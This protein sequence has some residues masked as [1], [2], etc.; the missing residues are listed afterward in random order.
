[1]ILIAYKIGIAYD[2]IRWEER[3]L[4]NAFKSLGT[5]P[6]LI[7]VKSNPLILTNE[8]N[9]GA[10]VVLQRCMSNYLARAS[11][12][13]LEG[14]GVK[15]VNSAEAIAKCSDKLW[16]ATILMRNNL[17]I[18]KVAVAFSPEGV[19]KAIESF[20][21]PSVIKPISG[22]WGRLIA[23]VR[24][25]E[26]LRTIMEHRSYLPGQNS[27][28]HLIQ[29]FIKKPG[30]DLRVFVVGD[31]VPVAI[32]RISE[33]WITNAA[34]GGKAVP[35][36]VDQE[37]EELVIKAAKA[38]GAE[39]VGVDVFEDPDRGYLID[40]VNPVPEFKRTVAATGYDLPKKVAEY[41]IGLIR[42]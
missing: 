36:K 7:H 22:S 17:P 14:L 32:Y 25:E 42:R 3:A 4:I 2:V 11:T 37:L 38:L 28:V 21:Y 20:G 13:A 9:V 15:V 10:E 1:M 16:S 34:R 26:E 12:E 24:D 8:F 6:V 41:L 27:K 40:E 5:E 29:E 35:A 30:R 33:H 23:L 18:P 39:F 19:S 31:E